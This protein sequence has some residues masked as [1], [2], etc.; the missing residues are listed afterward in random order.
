MPRPHQRGDT[1]YLRATVNRLR[2]IAKR[3]ELELSS[4]G[5]RSSRYRLIRVVGPDGAPNSRRCLTPL[6]GLTL[7]RIESWL[8][9][10]EL[11]D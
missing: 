4:A 2:R 5:V 3:H 6:Y 8:T 1:A 10:Y 9:D 11:S 7:D